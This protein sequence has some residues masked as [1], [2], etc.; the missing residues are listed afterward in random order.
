MGTLITKILEETCLPANYLDLEVTGRS[1]MEIRIRPPT[2][3]KIFV[4]SL[5]LWS[6]MI[7]ALSIHH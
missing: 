1:L 6:S 4:N 3:L 7:L 2:F 5:F